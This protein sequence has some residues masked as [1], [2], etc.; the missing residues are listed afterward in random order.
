MNFEEICKTLHSH[1]PVASENFKLN[2][3]ADESEFDVA[4]AEAVQIL[5]LVFILIQL[6][7]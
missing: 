3:V 5:A 7:Q 2:I 6:I 1:K 4:G